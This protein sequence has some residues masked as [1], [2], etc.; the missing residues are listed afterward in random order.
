MSTWK[1]T[2]GGAVIPRA[3]TPEEALSDF[4][5]LRLERSQLLPQNYFEATMTTVACAQDG[6]DTD[7]FRRAL[8][9]TRNDPALAVAYDRGANA[10]MADKYKETAPDH[11]TLGPIYIAIGRLLLA[12]TGRHRVD[13]FD[14]HKDKAP[15]TRQYITN[16]LAMIHES[17]LSDEMKAITFAKMFQVYTSEALK[18]KAEHSLKVVEVS[19][20][21]QL[22]FSK[23]YA[24]NGVPSKHGAATYIGFYEAFSFE[25]QHMYRDKFGENHQEAADI[26]GA[27]MFLETS[28]RSRKIS[29]TDIREHKLTVLTYVDNE[30][31]D[32]AKQYLRELYSDEPELFNYASLELLFAEGLPEA[33]AKELHPPPN[34]EDYVDVDL[35]AH[36][37]LKYCQQMLGLSNE[38]MVAEA[39]K[40]I[41]SLLGVITPQDST[42][43]S[44]LY[45]MLHITKS[46]AMRNTTQ[47]ITL[48]G[49][50][51]NIDSA[52]PDQLIRSAKARRLV[53]HV[54]LAMLDLDRF[55]VLDTNLSQ[56]EILSRQQEL[57]T[58]LH[59]ELDKR[60]NG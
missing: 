6:I 36:D 17:E 43:P 4:E 60:R 49:E 30:D 54:L 29:Q 51:Y 34:K 18:R 41:G 33:Q 14:G 40:Y 21:P 27:T 31:L 53:P 46:L 52:H 8:T 47:G 15:R 26:V 20:M 58:K 3:L 9:N 37:A 13:F 22:V 23:I 19:T 24:G 45:D 42:I 57:V 56:D 48:I 5:T 1:E 44:K 12:R 2:I 7:Q 10:G 35:K 25:L 39:E 59:I 50:S 11:S 38:E 16:E 28:N 32:S 55:V